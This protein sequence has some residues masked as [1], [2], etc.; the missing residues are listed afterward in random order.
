[1][2]NWS[3]AQP[4]SPIRKMCFSNELYDNFCD[5]QQL[6]NGTV[7]R[8]NTSRAFGNMSEVAQRRVLKYGILDLPGTHVPWNK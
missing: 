2:Q 1:M 3:F 8:L 6:D 4:N 5:V 7:L